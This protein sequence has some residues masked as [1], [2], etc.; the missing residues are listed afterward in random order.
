MDSDDAVTQM[1][2]DP[3]RSFILLLIGHWLYKDNPPIDGS[4]ETATDTTKR[5]ILPLMGFVRWLLIPRRFIHSLTGFWRWQLTIHEGSSSYWWVKSDGQNSCD[6]YWVLWD[7]HWPNRNVHNT[8]DGF[9]EKASDLTKS[10]ILLL[11][12]FARWPLM[13]QGVSSTHCWVLRDDHCL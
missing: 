1:A 2:K 4:R 12:G 7:I 11:M 5:F 8:I 9:C 3:A 13:L 10:F 6:H